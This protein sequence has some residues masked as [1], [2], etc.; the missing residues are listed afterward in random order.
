MDAKKAMCLVSLTTDRPTAEKRAIQRAVQMA[1]Q[2]AA[3]M[4]TRSVWWRDD[5]MAHYWDLQT[6]A[7][8]VPTTASP[9]VPAWDAS[10]AVLSEVSKVPMKGHRKDRHSAR[11]KAPKMERRW[12]DQMAYRKADLKA[13]CSDQCSA[14]RSATPKDRCWGR[15]KAVRL[16]QSMACRWE[17]NSAQRMALR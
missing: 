8:M 5:A 14:S 2:M 10:T 7:K 16:D 9:L 6:A 12:D 3:W 1:T 15:K 17:Q 11:L 13:Q 4:D